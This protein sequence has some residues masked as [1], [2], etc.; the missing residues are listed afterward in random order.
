MNECC[1]SCCNDATTSTLPCLMGSGVVRGRANEAA[2][3][4]LTGLEVDPVH[5]S[6]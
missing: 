6:R 5:A 3:T 2:S 4:G 1:C